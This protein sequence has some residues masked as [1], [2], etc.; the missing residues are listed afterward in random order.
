VEALQV[1][2]RPDVCPWKRNLPPK[3]DEMQDSGFTG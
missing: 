1:S 3:L 2:R